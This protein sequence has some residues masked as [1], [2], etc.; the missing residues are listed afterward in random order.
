MKICRGDGDER[1]IARQLAEKDALLREVHH[2]VKN[3]LYSI[4]GLLCF[5]ADATGSAEATAAI[6]KAISRVQSVRVLYEQLSSCEECQSVSTRMYVERLVDTLMEV[7]GERHAI[8]LKTDIADF[9]LSARKAMP[10]GIIMTELLTN[11]LK[12]AFRG[13]A[14]GQIR[15]IV[16]RSADHA[17]LTVQDDGVGFDETAVSGE[18]PGLGLGIVRILADQLNGTCAVE[19][20]NGTTCAVTFD[21]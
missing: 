1:T 14:A 13:R 17:T 15:V 21:P 11:A 7:Y 16:V 5:E 6:R 19:N 4:E 20:K 3:H 10:V 12:H 9:P 2:R 18:S 8:A